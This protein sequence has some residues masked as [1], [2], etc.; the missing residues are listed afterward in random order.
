MNAYLDN[1]ATTFPKPDCVPQA[2]YEF[3]TTC[4]ANVGRGS[5]AS[6]FDIEG[7]V[8]ETREA[9][10]ALFGAPDARDIAFTRNVT[11]SLNLLIKGLLHEGDHVIVSS[12]E[13]NAVMRP[14]VQLGS[15]GVSFTRCPCDETGMLDVGALAGCLQPNTRAVVMLHASNVTGTVMPAAKVGEFC[16][17][18][19]LVFIL[20]A[21]QTAG[22]L[23]INMEAMGI[24]AV[25]F[26]GH[27]GLLGPQGIGGVA[28]TEELAHRVEPLVVGGTGSVSDKETI[29]NFM[30][31]RLE[32]GTPN[33][34]G[35]V[36][37]HAALGWHAAQGKGAVLAH[38]LGLTQRFLE[39]LEPLERAGR[40]R[41]CGR[42]DAEKRVGV[43]SL[44]TPGRDEAEAATLLDELYHISVC[45]GLHCA[46]S[47]HKTIGTFPTGAV[48]FSFGFFNTEDDVD[49]AL[50]ALKELLERR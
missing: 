47:A 22:V 9:L 24:D 18:H 23:P 37:L 35:I 42:H 36:G 6:A 13:H 43:V 16:R 27:K 34:P 30:P 50:D 14:L 28:L 2:M 3:M 49:Y 44:A 11:E 26:T 15:R 32:A 5:Y 19:G 8:L 39:G 38:E 4:G 1:A 31:D 25:A 33:L 40:V 45:V 17:T 29:P 12:M 41:V 46:P 21:A 48:R 10:A 20:D 7:V